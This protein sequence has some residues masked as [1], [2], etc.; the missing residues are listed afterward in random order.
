MRIVVT[1]GSSGLI[2]TA[3]GRGRCATDGHEVAGWCGTGRCAGRGAWDPA[4]GMLDDVCRSTASTRSSTSPAS[5]WPT[6][7]GARATSGPSWTAGST[8]RRRSRSG[9]RVATRDHGPA[10]CSPQARSATTASAARRSSRESAPTGAGFL[11]DVVRQWEAATAPPPSWR[12]SGW[13][14]CAPASC[15]QRAAARSARCCRCSSSAS[16]ASSARVGS[17]CRGSRWPTRSRRSGSCSR[18]TRSRGR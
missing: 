8:V 14:T 6:S 10:Y 12:A 11:A 17:G 1:A 16:A 13:C 2:G 15:C 9:S 5:G 4:T 3:L 18:P 7:A